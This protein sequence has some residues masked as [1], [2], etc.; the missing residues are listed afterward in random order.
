[1]KSDLIERLVSLALL[2]VFA[3]TTIYGTLVLRNPEIHQVFFLRVCTA[4]AA[5]AVAAIIPGVIEIQTKLYS[6]VI[7]ATG[8]IAVFLFVY[9]MDPG[10]LGANRVQLAELRGEYCFFAVAKGPDPGFGARVYG[11]PVK[12]SGN[13]DELVARVTL[14]FDDKGQLVNGG[15]SGEGWQSQHIALSTTGMLMYTY[16]MIDKVKVAGFSYLV[17]SRDDQDGSIPELNGFFQRTGSDS[18]VWGSL[19]MRRNEGRDADCRKF[20]EA[21]YNEHASPQ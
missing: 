3:C 2:I 1:M 10:S 18:G 19:K 17:I 8:A 12:I 13:P 21:E 11:G 20:V 4:L 5:A 15:G 9:F 7:K 14:K 16:E 6:S